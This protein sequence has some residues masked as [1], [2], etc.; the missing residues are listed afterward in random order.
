M[1]TELLTDYHND[2]AS[3]TQSELR[4][5]VAEYLTD[6]ART[7]EHA[8]RVLSDVLE[9]PVALYNYNQY[10]RWELRSVVSDDDTYHVNDT[11]GDPT[12]SYTPDECDSPPDSSSLV[13]VFIHSNAIDAS[14]LKLNSVHLT[15]PV[16]SRAYAT[17]DE[18]LTY[19]DRQNNATPNARKS[20]GVYHE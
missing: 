13:D 16:A 8:A 11:G 6:Q 18:Q 7:T 17:L 19:R 14:V 1:K 10:S 3:L 12:V 4:D 9:E 20:S 15:G 5:V 2:I